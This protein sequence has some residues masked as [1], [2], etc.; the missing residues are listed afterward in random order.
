LAL[1]L[2]GP[3]DALTSDF[4]ND[5]G[6]VQQWN[7]FVADVAYQPGDFDADDPEG[8]ESVLCRFS[9]LAFAPTSPHASP[10]GLK[11]NPKR[12]KKS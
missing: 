12:A 5:P 10:L 6:K 8:A 2:A 9:A 3:P 11:V 4:V 7:S 1:P